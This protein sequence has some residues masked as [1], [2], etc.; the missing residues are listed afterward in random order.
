VGLPHLIT[1]RFVMQERQAATVDEYLEALTERDRNVL[2]K[3]RK[4][5]KAAAPEAEETISYRMPTFKY[6]GMLVSFAAFKDHLSL[7]VMSPSVMKAHAEELQGYDTSKGTI[8]FTTEKPPPV[9]PVKKLVK[10]R[11]EENL[12]LREKGY[13]RRSTKRVR[14]PM[15]DY[16]E[17]ELEGRGLMDA[18][19]QPPPYQ[20]NDYVG[21]ITTARQEATRQRRLEQMLEE[22]ERGDAYMKMP[23]KPKKGKPRAS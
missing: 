21:W 8:R 12:S 14:H 15:P 19:K 9:P 1:R 2:Q 11:V 17:R 4:A 3:L 20:R 5:I 23:Y 18:Y 22:L 6:H 10:A 13:R 7:F 16:V